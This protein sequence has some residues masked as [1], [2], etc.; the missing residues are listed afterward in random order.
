MNDPTQEAEPVAAA[1]GNSGIPDLD[2]QNANF[3]YKA[4]EEN[5]HAYQPNKK[6][7]VRS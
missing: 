4:P 5:R 1:A 6:F 3:G 7:E 2:K